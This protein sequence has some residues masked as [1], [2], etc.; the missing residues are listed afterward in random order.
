M[1]ERV[2]S[3]LADLDKYKL[4]FMEDKLGLVA[5]LHSLL[6]NSYLEVRDLDQALRHHQ[7]NLKI[8]LDR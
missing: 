1:R 8:G 3:I 7:E 5:T 2:H 6:G 4:E